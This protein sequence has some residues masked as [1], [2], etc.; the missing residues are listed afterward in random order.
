ME[1][2]L[3]EAVSYPGQMLRKFLS[4][5]GLFALAQHLCLLAMMR[6]LCMVVHDCDVFHCP[7]RPAAIS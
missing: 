1:A 2:S 5:Q 6:T 4:Y 7:V 3:L